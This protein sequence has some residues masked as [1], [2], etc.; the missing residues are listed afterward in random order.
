[1]NKLD[2]TVKEI[3]AAL[4]TEQLRVDAQAHL[5]TKIF[6][7]VFRHVAEAKGDILSKVNDLDRQ[8]Y[9]AR[10]KIEDFK[11]QDEY[12]VVD[13]AGFNK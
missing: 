3:M 2:E 9:I 8:L 10:K 13:N 7:I 5:R 12:Y 4:P 11:V 6:S 1:M